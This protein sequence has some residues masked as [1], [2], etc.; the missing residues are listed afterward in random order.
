MHAFF[1]IIFHYDL[2]QD[3]DCSSLYYTLPIYSICN[4]LHLLIQNS[5]YIPLLSPC[6][7]YIFNGIMVNSPRNKDSIREDS[8]SEVSVPVSSWVNLAHKLGTTL[9]LLCLS[10]VMVNC[11]CQIM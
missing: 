6:Q 2:P 5:Q 9:I 7:G 10:P 3:I 11:M 4:S 8:I 1:C